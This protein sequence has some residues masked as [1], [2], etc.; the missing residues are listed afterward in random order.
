[1]SMLPT[2]GDIFYVAEN[3]VR[4]SKTHAHCL[5]MMRALEDAGHGDSV[6]RYLLD[7]ALNYGYNRADLK[8]RVL[9]IL[10]GD[11]TKGTYREDVMYSYQGWDTLTTSAG[12]TFNINNI[13]IRGEEE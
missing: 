9:D 12:V 10:Y 7:L 4:G 2:W 3:C 1:M 11:Y 5:S 13:N 6:E 8:A